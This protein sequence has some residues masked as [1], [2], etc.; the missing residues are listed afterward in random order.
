MFFF[1]T[2]KEWERH[3][4]FFLGKFYRMVEPGLYF[5]IPL[6]TRVLYRIDLRIIT[7]TVPM[8]V[9]LTKDNIPVEVDAILFYQVMDP[10]ACV[11]NVDNYHKATQLSARS[12]IRDMVGKSN[13]DELLAER[14][15]IGKRLK[16]HIDGFVSKWGVTVISVEIKDVIVAK[17]L[18]DAIAREAAAER[19]KRARVILA[20]AEQLAADA[21]IAASKKYADNPIALQLRSM[22]MLYE[23]CLEG[24][25]S[26]VFIPTDKS[27][28]AMPAFMGITSLEELIRKN[29]Q[30]H[31]SEFEKTEE[32]D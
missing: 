16:E 7:Y 27:M 29:S 31:S 13:L 22:N 26:V 19:E 8:Q 1:G 4:L 20:D 21:I 25:S 10:K 18:E 5:Y 6:V 17:E 2:V 30:T 15:K 28:G 14:D 11:L 9:G 12:S 23:I 32:D 24:K 3:A